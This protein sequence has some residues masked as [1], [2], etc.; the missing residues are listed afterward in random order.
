MCEIGRAIGA[1]RS[2]NL[3]VL[4]FALARISRISGSNTDMAFSKT[5]IITVLENRLADNKQMREASVRAIETG[6]G[7]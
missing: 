6:Y 4:G 1:P 5:D 2:V 3:V 7:Q